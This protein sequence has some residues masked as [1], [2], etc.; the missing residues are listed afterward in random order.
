MN[1]KTLVTGSLQARPEDLERLSALGLDI[2]VHPDERVLVENAEQYE[3]VIGNS[4]FYYQSFE[5]FTGLKY[6]QMTSAGYD[7]VPVE[8]MRERSIVLRNAEGVYS[9]PMAEWTVM[10]ILDLLKKTDETYLKQQNRIYT[11]DRK[12]GELCGKHVLLVGYGAYGRAIAQRLGGFDV[13]LTVLNRTLRECP[14]AEHFYGLDKLEEELPKA[15]ILVLAIGLVPETRHL[16][17]EKALAVL[18]DGALLINA[19]RG[20]IIDEPALIRAL[21]SGKLAG[22]ALDVFEEE[23]LP[24]E[25]PL[26]DLPHVLLSPHNS[27][28][29]TGNP[30][31]M[32]ALVERNLKEY[33]AREAER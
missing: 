26:W 8:K 6:M 30:D 1:R 9:A 24:K 10:R 2:T 14:Q 13:H 11:K 5:P 29:S 22:A 4:L 18:K 33:L 28:A 32:I 7:R 21:Q 20:G 19:S 23:P 12:W 25:S 15:D 17:G 31:R 27:F 16:I 3:I